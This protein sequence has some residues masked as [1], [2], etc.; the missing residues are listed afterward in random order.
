MALDFHFLRFRLNVPRLATIFE[1]LQAALAMGGTTCL[2]CRR[3]HARAPCNFVRTIHKLDRA[4]K[5]TNC[6]VF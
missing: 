1:P 5:V 6:A 2:A 3:T 4:N